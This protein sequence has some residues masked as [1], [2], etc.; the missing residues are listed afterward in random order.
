MNSGIVSVIITT[1]K[2]SDSIDR[3]IKSVLNQTYKNIEVIVVDDNGLDSKEQLKTKQI[4]EK[5]QNIK[6]IVHEK[7]KNGSAARNTGMK[8]AKGEFIALLDDDDEFLP[9]KIEKQYQSIKEKNADICYTG[10]RVVFQNG[11]QRDVCQRDEGNLFSLVLQRRIE[12]PTSVLMFRKK[13]AER[14][15]GFDESFN[16]HQDWEFL[17][18]LSEKCFISCVPE[19]CLVRHIV[20]RNIAKNI[21]Q[22]IDQRMFY[23]KKQEKYICKLS[24]SDQKEVYY[25]H[26]SEI[27]RA[28][29]KAKEYKKAIYW[30][31]KTGQPFRLIKDSACKYQGY[32]KRIGK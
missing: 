9:C 23:L 14:I 6:Y 2:G 7:N 32:K 20:E 31:L 30:F 22:F 13:I 11:I 18:R 15:K 8:A 16:R 26:Y 3:A 28:C 10:L 29:V 21:Q 4:V 12:A 24:K 1:Y 19:V 25:N 27:M 5:Y 17:D